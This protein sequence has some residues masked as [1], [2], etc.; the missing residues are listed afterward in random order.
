MIFLEG[1]Q[2][3]REESQGHH[4]AENQ[5]WVHELSLDFLHPPCPA[6]AVVKDRGQEGRSVSC[7]D[8]TKQ[9]ELRLLSVLILQQEKPLLHVVH[10]GK[11]EHQLLNSQQFGEP[12]FKPLVGM[13]TP[14]RS[15]DS[16]DQSLLVGYFPSGLPVYEYTT[17]CQISLL[18]KLNYKGWS[19]SHLH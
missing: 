18:L 7:P 11:S 17:D 3:H 13:F 19:W 14:Q 5:S 9:A 12:I 8:H 10:L 15:E 1:Q 2:C 16:A 4:L 6:Q